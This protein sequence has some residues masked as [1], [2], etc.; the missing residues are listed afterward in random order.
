MCIRD[1]LRRTP[2]LLLSGTID[3][4]I[5]FG[6]LNKVVV[7]PCSL[8][9]NQK[10]TEIAIAHELAHL[11]RFDSWFNWLQNLLLMVWWFN[12]LLWILNWQIRKTRED[13]CDDLV[14]VNQ[15]FNG[16]SYSAAL[17]EIAKLSNKKHAAMQTAFS[18]ADH[19]LKDRIRRIMNPETRHQ[20]RISCC[21]LYTSPSPRDATLSRMPSS[22]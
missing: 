21:L 5:S 2:K 3:A 1:R 11:K 17:I 6:C 14:L 7:L 18:M 12:P 9:K 22:A 13:C 8:T 16:E 20:K 19:P 4:P 15:F 10:Y